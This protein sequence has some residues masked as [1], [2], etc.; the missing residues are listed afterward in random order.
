MLFIERS[1]HLLGPDIS[2]GSMEHNL[3]TPELD[4]FSRL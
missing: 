4:D 3:K 2:L 1:P